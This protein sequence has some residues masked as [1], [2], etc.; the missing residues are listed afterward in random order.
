MGEKVNRRA[1]HGA[2]PWDILA[3]LGAALVVGGLA[4]LSVPLAMIAAGAGIVALAIAG[5]RNRG[6]TRAAPRAASESRKP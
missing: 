3:V 1:G 2:D 6:P 5:A 4:A